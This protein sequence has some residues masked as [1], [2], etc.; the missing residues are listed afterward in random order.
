[1]SGF[2]AEWLQLRESLDHTSRDTS[3][4]LAELGEFASRDIKQVIDLGCGTGSNLR[5]LLPLLGHGQQWACIDHDNG[6][7]A[8]MPKRLAS[9]YAG[10]AQIKTDGSTLRISSPAFSANVMRLHADLAASV[11]HLEIPD[12]S[13]VT[14]SA[15]LDLV[16]ASWVSK[17][18]VRCL[19]HRA[20]IL[21]ALTYNGRMEFVP[22]DAV[23]AEL[24]SLVNRH[25][26]KDKGFGPALGPNAN[27][28]TGRIFTDLGYR[29]SSAD[30]RWQ[31]GPDAIELQTELLDGW[32]AA[33]LEMDDAG[34]KSLRAWHGRRLERIRGG[35][36]AMSVG[37]RD[38][39]GTPP[40]Q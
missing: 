22:Q 1:M 14:A 25:Q 27:D 7:L 2:S 30:S 17:L 8:E 5:W 9:A 31:L 29:V 15:L 34:E 6:L 37:H 12:S 10:R 39:V 24:T 36:S 32:L 3:T 21:F 20:H 35:V 13:L 33:A 18:A 28:A 11:E 40:A 19:A 38:L 23:D 4:V 26:R 16:S